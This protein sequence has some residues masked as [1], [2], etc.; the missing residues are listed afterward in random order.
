MLNEHCSSFSVVLF[1]SEYRGRLKANYPICRRYTFIQCAPSG[2]GPN[3]ERRESI[4]YSEAEAA[5]IRSKIAEFMTKN[6]IAH[7]QNGVIVNDKD[8]S[9]IISEVESGNKARNSNDENELL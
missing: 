4:R 9:K 2:D 5:D 6:N 8:A 7:R 1:E 3:V